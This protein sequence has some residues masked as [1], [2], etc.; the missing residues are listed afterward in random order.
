MKKKPKRAGGWRIHKAEINLPGWPIQAALKKYRQKTPEVHSVP[1]PVV[2]RQPSFKP[3][4]TR[5]EEGVS[6][7]LCRPGL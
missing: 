5:V 2:V 1:V 6:T 7:R 3:V 4:A